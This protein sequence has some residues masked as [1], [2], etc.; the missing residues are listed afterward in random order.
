MVL[1]RL[2]GLF[3]RKREGF[4]EDVQNPLLVVVGGIGWKLFQNPIQFL[5]G[6]HL[7]QSFCALK[8]KFQH[9]WSMAEPQE[10]ATV[11]FFLTSPALE[12]F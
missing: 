5:S 12:Y 3:Y 1:K 9:G 4:G 2:T 10:M 7:A 8:I 6:E 11:N